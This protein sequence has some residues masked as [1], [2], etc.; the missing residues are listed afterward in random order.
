MMLVFVMASVI[1]ITLYLEIPRIAMQTQRDKEQILIDRG[2]QYK[3]A[4]QLFVKKAGRYPGEIKDLE[5]FQNQ[6]FLRQRYADPMTGKDDWRLVHIQNGMLTDSKVAKPAAPGQKDGG[7]TSG[8]FV[9]E[10]L[11][12]GSTPNGQAGGAASARDRRRPN[13]SG[14]A[15]MPGNGQ[16][17]NGLPGTDVSG[18]QTTGIALM[19][20]Q[21]QPGQQQPGQPQPGQLQPGQ[22]LPPGALP[23]NF[24]GGQQFPGMN[25]QPVTG[26]NGQP[27]YPPG[28]PGQVGQPGF[29]G[30]IGG[31]PG[32]IPGSSVGSSGGSS[33]GAS[34]GSGGSFVGGGGS[35]VGGGGS[36]VGGGSATGSQ[37]P[38]PGQPQYPG[39][40]G[41]TLPGQ[42]GPPANSQNSGGAPAYPIAPGANG[43]A[44]GFPQPGATTG[45]GNAAA[46]LI[47]NIL[48]T[49]RAGGMPT[50]NPGAQ[51]IGGGIAGVASNGE[52]EGVKVYH[53][54]TLYA[55][56]EF[57]FDPA[58]QKQIPNPNVQGAGGTP[59]NQIGTPAGQQPGQNTPQGPGPGTGFG[60]G[61]S[62][63]P[64]R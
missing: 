32:T 63:Q 51:T 60:Q 33:G 52:G 15:G 12:M 16:P 37:T 55:E 24:P 54:R 64:G 20:G 17:G 19:P 4:I 50:N 56:W 59:V 38:N 46:D 26:A 34:A 22:T 45:Q 13:E 29:P 36:Y 21:Q 18:V 62:P 57:I 47:R 48:T 10:Q 9:G 30:A 41:Q 2:E 44:P 11:A 3:R 8:Q 53:D 40:P 43:Q 31:R 1:A 14:T 42:P 28:M 58:K 35:Y 23:P 39:Q 6:R 49:P 61:T 25:G 5:S 27:V 7:T